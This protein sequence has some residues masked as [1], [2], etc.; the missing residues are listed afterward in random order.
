VKLAPIILFVYN[1]PGHT[2]QTLEAL[3]LN[4]YASESVLYIYSD[5]LKEEASEESKKN[6]EAVRTTIRKKQ[7]CKE[8][9]IV[10]R[11]ENYGLAKSVI[12]GVSEVIIRHENVIVLEDDLITASYFLKYMNEGLQLYEDDKQVY[13]VTGYKFPSSKEIK[14]QTYFLPISCSWSFGTWADRWNTINFDAEVLLKKIDA[15]KLQKKLNFGGYPFYEMLKDQCTGRVNS[16]A[17]L[18]YTSMFLENGY[19]LFPNRTLVENIGFDNSG[20][21]YTDENYFKKEGKQ[22]SEI[23][24]NKLNVRLTKEAVDLIKG[25]FETEHLK[26]NQSNRSSSLISKLVRKGKRKIKKLLRN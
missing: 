26:P 25:R 9:I 24:V 6:V 11:T 3:H 2:E 21:H 10:E 5:G 1:R 23:I 19:F 18:F 20:T 4:E 15:N 22:T 8:V 13:G 14:D 7:W 16:W 17:I 12:E